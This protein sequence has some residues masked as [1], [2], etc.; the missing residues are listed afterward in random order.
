MCH[1]A[2]RRTSLCAPHGA[3]WGTWRTSLRAVAVSPA[4]E[5]RT[6]L[7]AIHSARPSH[8]DRAQPAP[9][10]VGPTCTDWPNSAGSTTAGSGAACTATACTVC[11]GPTVQ[12]VMHNHKYPYSRQSCTT[13]N[14]RIAGSHA[15]PARRGRQAWGSGS[16]TPA[17]R[18]VRHSG[19]R[20]LHPAR[21][22][23]LGRRL[24]RLA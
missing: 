8:T 4:S 21:E 12:A 11:M 17:R 3:N 14:I 22:A 5:A 7:G 15:Q 13:I 1:T 24:T 16:S 18:Q 20:R 2:V 6:S 10:R 23:P 9:W 19:T